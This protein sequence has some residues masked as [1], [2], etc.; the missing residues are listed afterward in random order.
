MGFEGIGK[1]CNSCTIFVHNGNTDWRKTLKRWK[2][3]EQKYVFK[4]FFGG[5]VDL[6]TPYYTIFFGN[7]NIFSHIICQSFSQFL[8]ELL[9]QEQK[10]ISLKL[11]TMIVKSEHMKRIYNN[12]NA[13]KGI[14]RTFKFKMSPIEFRL[15]N[16]IKTYSKETLFLC[17]IWLWSMYIYIFYFYFSIHLYSFILSIFFLPYWY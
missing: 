7:I 14:K 3:M 6:H 16:R 1:G 15:N 9:C 11:F 17:L 8:I 12:Y 13:T 10:E 4:C 2:G 5:G